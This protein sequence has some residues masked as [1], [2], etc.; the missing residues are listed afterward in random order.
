[1]TQPGT[2]AER[3]SKLKFVTYCG[4][5]CGLCANMAR[6]PKQAQ[7]LRE[8]MT[9]EGYE[10]F[11]KDSIEG[12]EPFWKVL[13]GLGRMDETC[14]GCRSGKCGYPGCKIREC[15]PAKRVEVCSACPEF[16]CKHFEGLAA[17]Y[18]NLIA[19]AKRQQK[20]GL[21]QWIQEQEERAR[22]GFSYVDIR[23]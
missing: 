6:I 23:Y 18:P 22:T 8:T 3:I 21:D 9:K 15:A 1:M 2:D 17:R 19:D 5:Y 10:C 12:F 16:P 20:V 14:P 11:G 13:E 4:L 7:A